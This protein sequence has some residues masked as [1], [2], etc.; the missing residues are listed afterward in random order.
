M[1]LTR[2]ILTIAFVSLLSV[3]LTFAQY[4][5]KDSV[6]EYYVIDSVY[7]TSMLSFD[8]ILIEHLDHAISL[9]DSLNVPKDSTWLYYAVSMNSFFDKSSGK[10]VEIFLQQGYHCQQCPP[11][12]LIELPGYEM[13]LHGSFIYK[14]YVFFVLS[15]K[16]SIE[17]FD[18]L[19]FKKYLTQI[20]YYYYKQYY[21]DKF[22]KSIN[23]PI[24]V[25]FKLLYQDGLYYDYPLNYD[26]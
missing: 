3:K 24:K 10:S 16:R 6:P 20:N 1:S 19:F 13:I 26:D 21:S 25:G 18:K 9:I 12:Q 5:N 4:W 7:N 17:L 11:F 23:F 15:D 22:S 14:G 8:T 2:I